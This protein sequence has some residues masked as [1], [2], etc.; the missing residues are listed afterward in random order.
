[1]TDRLTDDCARLLKSQHGAIARWQAPTV[2]LA[3]PAVDGLLR[4]GRWRQ[5]YRGVYAAYTG[6]PPRACLLWAGV[7]RA[8]PGAVL[9]H[10]TAAE[11]DGLTDRPS[12]VTHVTVGLDRR[13]RI[14]AGERHPS[15]P[16][17]VVHRT[18]RLET[19][20]HPV[21]TPPRTRVEETILDLTQVC[22]NFDDAFSWLC[23]G[24]GRRLVTP[25][26]IRKAAGMRGRLRWRSDILGA[27]PLI[28]EGV[29]S[30]LEYRY[31]RDVEEAHDLPKAKRQAMMSRKSPL[32][33]SGYIDNLYAAF[34]LVVELDGRADHL[35][36]DRWRDIHRDN[37]NARSGIMTM[38]YSWTDVTRRPCEVAADVSGALR[39][40]GWAGPPRCCGP[41]CTVAVAS[42]WT[43]LSQ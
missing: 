35:V 26:L 32:P 3:L 16:R 6:V 4:H 11:L 39:E 41:A 33:R 5:L 20:R 18:D 2:G 8:G 22:A 40:R 31:A 7:L 30:P 24:C 29:H 28:A 15:A 23:K 34:G 38:R 14:S 17:I 13:V 36:E 43:I 27:L 21:R 12:T 25:R 19:V 9:S 37:A 10:D 1:M 42:T